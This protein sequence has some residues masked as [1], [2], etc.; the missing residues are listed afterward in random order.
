MGEAVE[1]D[2]VVGVGEAESLEGSEDV[3]PGGP[4]GTSFGEEALEVFVS[5]CLS[6]LDLDEAEH[7]EC[8]TDDADE[9]FDAVVVVQEDGT[10]S[11]GL[12]AVFVS[13]LDQG[14]VF[15]HG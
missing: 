6:Q 4:G 15:V 9:G 8:E 12:F 13:G 5:E 3:A 7:D 10:D 11:Q 14:L 2:A 1:D